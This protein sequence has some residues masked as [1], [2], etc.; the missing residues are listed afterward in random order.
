MARA[1][2]TL[3]FVLLGLGASAAESPLLKALPPCPAPA[4]LPESD[5]VA[6]D[7]ARQNGQ[8]PADLG[9]APPPVSMD[10]PLGVP[11][12]SVTKQSADLSLSQ[13][14]IADVALREGKLKDL[15]ILGQSPTPQPQGEPI[16]CTPTTPVT[17]P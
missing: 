7:P 1:F 10:I 15:R 9:G 16:A 4:D 6:Y 11:L 12:P 8:V 5:G 17:Q 3:F 2:F 13:V 14:P